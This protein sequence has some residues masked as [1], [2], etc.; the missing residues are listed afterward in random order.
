MVL[1]L[2]N[3]AGKIAGIIAV[4]VL[5]RLYSPGDFWVFAIFMLFVMVVS[6]LITLRYIVAIPLPRSDGVAINLFAVSFLSGIFH[7]VLLS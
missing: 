5:A 7:S 2:G 6:P 3:G 1:V 4:P